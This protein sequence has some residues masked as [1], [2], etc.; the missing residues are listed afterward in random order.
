MTDPSSTSHRT[1][2][3]LRLRILQTSDLHGALRGYDY[4][5]DTPSQVMGLSRTATLIRAARSGAANCLL[6]D[7][8]D[9]LQ[10][11]PVCDFA[12]ERSAAAPDGPP[13]PH[14]MI[15]AMNALGYDAATIG[16]HDF[17]HGADFLF[18]SLEQARF[19]IVSA[20]FL[21]AGP[22]GGPVFDPHIRLSRKMTDRNGG[23]HDIEIAVIGCLP[24]Q[25]IDWDHHLSGRFAVSDMVQSV[26]DQ[27]ALARAAGA[28]LVIVLAHS[29]IDPSAPAQNAENAL[30]ELAALDDVDV[31]LGGHTHMVF[32]SDAAPAHPAIDATRGLIHGKPVLMPGFWGN[33]LG[34]LDLDLAR[35]S[36]GAWRLARSRSKV[37]ALSRRDA[38]GRLTH[39][40]PED[41]ALSA[42]TENDH[43]ATLRHIR[44]PAGE[45]SV[46]LHS[47]FSL[48]AN[49]AA[50]QLVADAQ[51]DYLARA[52]RGSPLEGLPILSSAAPLKTGRRSGP[53]HY[54]HIRPGPLT[55]RSLADLYFYPNTLCAVH[56]TGAALRDWLEHSASL[57][58]RIK[59]GRTGSQIGDPPLLD[60]HFP[61]YKFDV[62]SGLTY[63][64]DLSQ[65]P[66]FNINSALTNPEARRIRALQWQGRPVCD[67]DE[68]LLATNS[69]RAYGTGLAMLAT[70][71][72]AAPEI[73]YEAAVSNRNIL[74]DFIRRNSPLAHTTRKI[75]SF[76]PLQG[77]TAW[78]DTA[79]EA[80]AYLDDPMLPPLEDLGDTPQGF[81]RFRV[82][83]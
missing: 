77:A 81:T 43:S 57:F 48:L 46:P 51:S 8:G 3:A 21:G 29:G 67:S 79:P 60:E 68:F 16:N 61:G 54:T 24:P 45:T 17:N 5:A 30:I 38:S 78:F 59:P 53:Q 27:A 73:V 14:P 37:L 55:R 26:R 6:F 4:L 28:D 15:A 74:L 49:D 47:F 20:N 9:F 19:P 32:P 76:T 1:P 63:Q 66:R 56:L 69:Y 80:R 11:T 40:T 75:W 58:S 23:F 52:I 44:Q 22:T 34:R 82:T 70:G 72:S 71:R 42:T 64:I 31:V 12:A 2:G 35:D 36:S 25:T 65:P 33:H 13:A 7:C 62:I 83:L 10:G 41:P 50:V 39:V 18:E